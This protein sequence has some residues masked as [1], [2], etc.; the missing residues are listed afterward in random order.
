[1]SPRKVVEPT[2]L[3]NHIIRRRTLKKWSTAELA[4]QAKIPY[5]TLRNIEKGASK[6]PDEQILRAII[7]ALDLDEGVVF[8]YAGYGDIPKMTREELTV[9]LD[10][11]GDVAPDWLELIERIKKQPPDKQYQMYT[12]LLAQLNAANHYLKD[13]P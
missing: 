5:T 3:G 8:A 1:M 2:Q 7:N 11:L 12:V 6:K 9:N 4:R 10:A 13:H